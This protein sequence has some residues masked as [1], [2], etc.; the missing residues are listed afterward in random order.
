MSYIPFDYLRLR[1]LLVCGAVVLLW[2]PPTRVSAADPF[3]TSNWVDLTH[4]FSETTIF[5]PTE[6]GFRLTKGANGKTKKGYYYAANRFSSAEHGG[7]HLD[8]PR[9]F[10]ATGLTTDEI[11]LGNLIGEAVVIDVSAK[12]ATNRDYEVSIDDLITWE[13]TAHQQLVDR[14]VLLRTD[15]SRHWPDRV[16]YLGTDGRGPLAIRD[17]HFPGLAPTAAKWLVDHRRPKAIG[18]DTASI[19][20]G[21][22]SDFAAHVTL[23]G[24]NIPIFE[25]LT[26]LSEMPPIGAVVIALPM[27]I[28][29]GSGGPLRIIAK[30]PNDMPPKR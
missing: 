14:I 4:V 30:I 10:S 18:I 7:T 21:Q 6:S 2:L 11:P 22:S 12:S 29:G 3:L 27:K 19:D 28:G 16:A 20:Y 9:H 8:A 17:L 24:A 26:K 25:N 5:W 1:R 13:Q 23:C 15:W